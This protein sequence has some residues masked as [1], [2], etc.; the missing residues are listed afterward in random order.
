MKQNHNLTIIYSL[1][2]ETLS[3]PKLQATVFAPNNEAF[4]RLLRDTGATL[5]ALLDAPVDILKSLLEYHILPGPGIEAADLKT[6]LRFNTLGGDPVLVE[7]Q[8][9]KQ[10]PKYAGCTSLDIH[11]DTYIDEDPE[12]IICDIK[13]CTALVHIVD[14]LLIPNE[15]QLRALL[16]KGKFKTQLSG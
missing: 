9:I 13:A 12:P 10:D 2:T 1:F 11:L 14:Y 6:G 4:E 8:K 3:D 16:P 5:E 7:S 15:A